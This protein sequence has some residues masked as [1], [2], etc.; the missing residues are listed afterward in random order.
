MNGLF[1]VIGLAGLFLIVF[2]SMFNK[3]RK[4][5]I[6]VNEALAQIDVQLKRRADLIPNLVETVKGYAAH[7]SGT[8]LKVTEAR[9]KSM[10]ATTFDEKVSSDNMLTG[11]LRGLLAITENYPDLKASANFLALQEELSTTEN[12]I[13]FAR[14]YY[15]DSVLVANSLVTTIPTNLLAGVA[16]VKVREFYKVENEAD[17]KLPD[18]KF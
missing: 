18:V 4:A 14:Q 11:A 3:L 8:F 13:A 2:V 12:K 17:V 7:E 15:N 10:Q 5:N 9:A 1:L 6:S 16:G